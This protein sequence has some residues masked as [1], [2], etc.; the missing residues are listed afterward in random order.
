[1]RVHPKTSFKTQRP[2]E[3]TTNYSSPFL[4][5]SILMILLLK[6]VWATP[7]NMQMKEHPTFL[8]SSVPAMNDYL[9]QDLHWHWFMFLS[10]PDLGNGVGNNRSEE[11]NG[12]IWWLIFLDFLPYST[13]ISQC[14]TISAL[15]AIEEV[16]YS[17]WITEK[18][19]PGVVMEAWQSVIMVRFQYLC[20]HRLEMGRVYIH[21]K[22]LD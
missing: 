12:S 9:L 10:A 20:W 6:S 18:S 13:S 2:K 16:N 8:V 14:S 11:K 3:C 7:T 4:A 19:G 15:R 5:A 22:A 21:W 1:M 17:D